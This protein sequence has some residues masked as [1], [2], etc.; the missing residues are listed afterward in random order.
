MHQTDQFLKPNL[1]DEIHNTI[2][3]MKLEEIQSHCVVFPFSL[4]FVVCPN[5]N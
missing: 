1:C 4:P 5:T 3:E 2:H